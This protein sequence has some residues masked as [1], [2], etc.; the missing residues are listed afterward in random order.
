LV[1][2]QFAD[3][4]RPLRTRIMHTM[5]ANDPGPLLWPGKAMALFGCRH[6]TQRRAALP[7]SLTFEAINAAFVP[8]KPNTEEQLRA[9]YHRL[10]EELKRQK[11]AHD[12]EY[13]RLNL[14]AVAHYDRDRQACTALYEHDRIAIDAEYESIKADLP[15]PCYKDVDAWCVS[16][17]TA[18][19]LWKS[20]CEP[21]LQR[22]KQRSDANLKRLNDA[23]D[24]NFKQWEQRLNQRHQQQIHAKPQL[25]TSLRELREDRAAAAQ[26]KRLAVQH[27]AAFAEL[28]D[29][30]AASS[31]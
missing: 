15:P 24:A 17:R 9:D 4:I 5:T 30:P 11:Q 2:K 3:I 25:D 28:Y 7:P 26:A 14:E 23:R 31:P 21:M 8:T 12:E 10:C 16:Q 1:S 6:S 27:G 20:H 18:I 29:P 22:M 19:A 13:N